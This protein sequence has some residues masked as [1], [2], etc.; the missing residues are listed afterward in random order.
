[1]TSYVSYVLRGRIAAQT[2]I[3]TNYIY[4]VNKD[5]QDYK[6]SDKSTWDT[7]TL[8]GS[9]ALQTAALGVGT[10]ATWYPAKKAFAVGWLATK[11]LSGVGAVAGRAAMVV[12]P[13]TA[14][15][16]IGA[17][18]GTGISYAIFGDDGAQVALGF[19]S[20]GMLPGTEAPTLDTYSNLLRPSETSTPGPVDLV[21]RVIQGGLIIGRKW[22]EERPGYDYRTRGS[23]YLM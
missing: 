6:A 23:P 8:I 4:Q 12:A 11:S 17:V 22:W 15:Y 20:L 5:V 1:M 16:M 19:Y 9:V 2:V 3:T 14:G 18:I 7:G 21:N 13:I 10:V